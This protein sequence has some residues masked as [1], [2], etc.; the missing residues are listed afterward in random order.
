MGA[1][2]VSD[3][4]L[5]GYLPSRLKPGQAWWGT[6]WLWRG[7]SGRSEVPS[8]LLTELL[9]QSFPLSLADPSLCSTVRLAFQGK[10]G[11]ADRLLCWLLADCGVAERD[12]GCNRVHGGPAGGDRGNLLFETFFFAFE[13]GV[14]LGRFEIPDLQNL[15]HAQILCNGT[16]RDG[17]HTLPDG[18]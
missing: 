5:Q 3:R 18:G 7:F 15:L 8:A 2:G 6:G 4:V 9:T 10:G 14:Q 13:N 17:L 11:N 1:D 12:F 16:Q